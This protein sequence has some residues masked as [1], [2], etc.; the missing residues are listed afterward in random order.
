MLRCRRCVWAPRVERSWAWSEDV[1]PV[2]LEF[3]LKTSVE[4]KVNLEFSLK[5]SVEPKTANRVAIRLSHESI[6]G[7]RLPSCSSG[8][9]KL[10]HNPL[11]IRAWIGRQSTTRGSLRAFNWQSTPLRCQH[12]EVIGTPD[13]ARPGTELRRKLSKHDLSWTL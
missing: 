4:P 9:E 7:K 1:R 6:Y 5:T 10:H 8:R 13:D 12:Q 11:A 3:S 2:N